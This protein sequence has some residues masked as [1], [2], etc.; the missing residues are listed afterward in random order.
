M[1]AAKSFLLL[2]FIAGA[3]FAEHRFNIRKQE[4]RI[5]MRDG[6]Q[7]GATLYRPE[8]EGRFPAIVFRTPYGKDQNSAAA[9]FALKSAKQSYLAFLVDVRGRYSSDGSFEAY[10]NEKRDGYD[11]IEWIARFP[12][13]N[14]KVGTYGRSYPGYVQWLALSQAPP[15]LQTAVPEMTPIH[16][17]HF[18]YV[19][20]AFTYSWFDWFAVNILPDL[21]RRAGDRSGPWEETEAAQRWNAEKMK[22]Y[23]YR[24][25]RENPFLRKYAPYYY[26]WLTHPEKTGFWEF[27]SVEKDFPKIKSPVLLISGW[28]D[29]VYGTIGA[30]EGFN[31]MRT[32]A[33]STEARENTRLILG[34]WTHGTISV[35]KTDIGILDAGLSAGM[36]YQGILLTW[37]DRWLK[38]RP[39]EPLPAVSIFVM[40]DNRWRSETEWPLSRAHE[41]SFYLHATKTLSIARPGQEASN[42]YVFDPKQPIWDPSYEQSLP[43]DQKEIES[44]PDVLVYSSEP[45]T[46]DLEVSGQIV[47]ELFV[48]SSARDTDFSITLCDV[49]PDGKSVNL[50]SL[51]AGFLRMRYRN[52][53]DKPEL[54]EPGK[55]YK[56][57]IDTLYTSN[58][59]QKGHS[60]RLQISSSKTPHYDPNPNTGTDLATETRLIPATQTIYLDEN[61]PSR[62]L[63]PVIYR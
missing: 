17:H 33:G 55:I 51:D 4:V 54:I 16:S 2:V 23:N 24:P 6:V 41:T 3:V 27:A 32:E 58:L 31:K 34:P 12:Q 28:Y 18:F 37:F 29:N 39:V 47:A 15:S 44:R 57:R 14:G 56:I 50:H 19:G 45:L 59:F 43:F 10:R 62:L 36:D 11:T 25:L 35:Q 52:G 38:G 48:T 60:I 30:T 40:G 8:Q 7:L 13:C 49:F 61:H 5:P 53:F 1:K 63:L 9:E 21:R 46:E 26:D 20:G 22:W 42:K